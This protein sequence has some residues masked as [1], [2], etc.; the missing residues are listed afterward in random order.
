MSEIRSSKSEQWLQSWC[1]GHGLANIS[2]SLRRRLQQA[3]DAYLQWMKDQG[4]PDTTR[5]DHHRE[6]QHLIALAKATAGHSEHFRGICLFTKKLNAP[7]K[8]TL[9]SCQKSMS[10]IWPIG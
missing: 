4:H 9:W 2:L 7:S 5:E 6:L 3:I 1:R 8:S 10:S